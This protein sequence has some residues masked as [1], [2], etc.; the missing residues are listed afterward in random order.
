MDI[1]NLFI[2]KISSYKTEISSSRVRI[3]T[4]EEELSA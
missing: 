2:D 1:N 3:K 4:L